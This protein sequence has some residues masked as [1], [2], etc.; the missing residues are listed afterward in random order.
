MYIT[1][2]QYDQGENTGNAPLHNWLLKT[3]DA[4][5]QITDRGYLHNYSFSMC[6]ERFGHNADRA[7]TL[8]ISIQ[9]SPVYLNQSKYIIF[10][11]TCQ[12]FLYQ[13]PTS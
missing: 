3:A 4:M 9:T 1:G 8:L 6:N 2:S 13:P 11:E 5:I 12:H 7:K 10:P